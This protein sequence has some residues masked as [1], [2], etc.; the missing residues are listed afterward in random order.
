MEG[1][2]LLAAAFELLEFPETFSDKPAFAS[3]SKDFT[4]LAVSGSES[5]CENS[6]SA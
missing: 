2:E 1:K 6:S 4:N 3:S 5:H